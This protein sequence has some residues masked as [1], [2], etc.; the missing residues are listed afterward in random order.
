M[1]ITK[2]NEILDTVLGKDEKLHAH[3]ERTAMYT[4]ALAKSLKLEPT[5][6]EAAYFAGLLHSVG[7][8]EVNSE[9]H[10]F[11]SSSMVKF[12]EELQYLSE[13]IKHQNEKWDGTGYPMGLQQD[14]IP[15]ISRILAVACDYDE[16][17]YDKDMAHED[18]VE[19][20]RKGSGVKY[21]PSMINPFVDIV[22][23]ED[24]INLN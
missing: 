19:V 22:E 13:G 2:I 8:T 24:L 17:R 14:T 20:L 1:T 6:M 9:D 16:M 11:V 23:K 21:D 12:I 4:F 15:L 7:K 3:L 10:V 18:V 5:D